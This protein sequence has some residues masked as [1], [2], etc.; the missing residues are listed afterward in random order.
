MT[1]DAASYL[2]VLLV[3]ISIALLL[4]HRKRVFDRTNR[5]GVEEFPTFWAK[6]ASRIKDQTI[7]ALALISLTV[8]TLVVA[9]HFEDSWGWLITL[10][11]YL[12]LLF[13]LLGS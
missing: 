3:A 10:P 4:W 13:G 7:K 11:I 2:G 8:G 9:F 1:T 6:L 5:F 12:V